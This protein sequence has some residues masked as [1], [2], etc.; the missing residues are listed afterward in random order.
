MSSRIAGSEIPNGAGDISA[1]RRSSSNASAVSNPRSSLTWKRAP[2]SVRQA[3]SNRP[4]PCAIQ[5]HAA[6]AGYWWVILLTFL[7]LPVRGL[8]AAS[9]IHAWGVWPVQALD[10]I[11]A[12]LQSVAVPALVVRLLNGTGRVN[13]GQGVAMTVQAAG[14]ALSP[15]LGGLLVHHFGYPAAFIALGAISTGSLVLWLYCGAA[16]RHACYPPQGKQ[17]CHWSKLHVAAVGLKAACYWAAGDIVLGVA[18]VL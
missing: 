6:A 8:I 17:T 16:L 11:G 9:L 2:I 15:A 13:A 3:P 12:G 10:G 14:A 1:R 18:S 4:G 7:A 5:S